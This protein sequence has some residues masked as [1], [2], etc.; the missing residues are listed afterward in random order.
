[1]GS[2]EFLREREL[3]KKGIAAITEVDK[4]VGVRLRY[5]GTGTVTSVTLTAATDVTMITSDGGTDAYTWVAY[6]TMGELVDAINKDGIFEAKILDTLRSKATAAKFMN[7]GAVASTLFYGKTI[8]D[9]LLDSSECD[10]MAYRLCYDRGF[11]RA[12]KNN[13]RVHLKEIKYLINLSG[14]TASTVSIYDTSYDMGQPKEE[15]LVYE[16]A[17]VD[18]VATTINWRGGRSDLT[19]KEAHDLVVLIPDNDNFTDTAAYL[20]VA[21]FIE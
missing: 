13:H 15:N 21:G 10:Y 20:R 18:N 8:W 14:A 12:N 7:T 1:M 11:E 2:L 3:R 4:N 9:L 17:T 19:A 6:A 16:V 5:I